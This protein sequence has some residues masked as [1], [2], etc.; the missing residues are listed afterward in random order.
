MCGKRD[1]DESEFF[2]VAEAL[3]SFVLPVLSG[4][5]A[6]DAGCEVSFSR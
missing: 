3:F 5:D 4:G 1:E 2:V 6:H